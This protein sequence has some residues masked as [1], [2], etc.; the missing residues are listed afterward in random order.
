M[1]KE[2]YNLFK[3]RIRHYLNSLWNEEKNN[4]FFIWT[5]SDVQSYL[6]SRL[7]QEFG[8]KYSINTNPAL[9]SKSTTKKYKGQA[10]NVKPFYQP[11]ILI[12]PISNLEVEKEEWS[13]DKKERRMRL[14]KKDDSIVVE[15]K[16][17]QDTN[18]SWGRKSTS[19]LRKLFE[20]Y[21]KVIEEGHK[22]VILIFYEKGRKSYINEVD[23]E[24]I[25]G[26]SRKFTLF[27]KPKTTVWD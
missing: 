23:I 14:Q 2:L 9:T 22:H 12:T 1:N 15:I 7:I 26:K 27:H 18:S 3:E 10:R 5:E 21:E 17:V 19:K 16:F 20:D 4:E 8:D 11:D 13:H 24:G 25:L 6:Y